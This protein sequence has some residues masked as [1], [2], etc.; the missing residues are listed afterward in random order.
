MGTCR[1]E[2]R[3]DSINATVNGGIIE[4]HWL[5]NV[6]I[7]VVVLTTLIAKTNKCYLVAGSVC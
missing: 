4:L 5:E 7:T 6:I 1:G 3:T 2:D